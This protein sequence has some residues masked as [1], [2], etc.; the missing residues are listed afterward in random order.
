MKHNLSYVHP[1]ANV[2]PS[3]YVGPHSVVGVYSVVRENAQIGENC[4]LGKEVLVDGNV[5][6]D[7]NVQVEDGAHL[8]TGAIIESDVVIGSRVFLSSRAKKTSGELKGN[9]TIRI[10]HGAYVGADSV[11]SA[12]VTVGRFAVV[13]PGSTVAY[14]VPD[15]ALMLGTPARQVGYVCSCYTR[16]VED[17]EGSFKCP[18]CGEHYQRVISADSGRYAELFSPRA[19]FNAQR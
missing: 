4:R 5:R 14:D 18:K 12:G 3:A 10:C 15:H 16:L 17:A 7:D 2:A 9:R 6:I 11:V 8:N 1:S 19:S 13:E